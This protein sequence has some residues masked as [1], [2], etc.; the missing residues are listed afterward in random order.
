VTATAALLSTLHA[1]GA[2]LRALP[3]GAIGV[4]PRDVLT[5]ADREALRQHK[6][7]VVALLRD[8]ARESA[9]GDG[10]AAATLDA[11]PTATPLTW[12]VVVESCQPIVGPVRVN[13]WTTITDP[14]KAIEA[15]LAELGLIVAARNAGREHWTFETLLPE[16][17]DRLAA[18]GVVAR[19]QA[20]Q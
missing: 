3:G 16:A 4:R 8:V 9:A 6:A 18:C 5:D 13:A 14:V 11:V 10:L 7:E 12:R 17:L 15:D 19:V 1:R 2:R 20:L